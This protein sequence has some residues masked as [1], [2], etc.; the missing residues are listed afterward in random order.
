MS[1]QYCQNGDEYCTFEIMCWG[2]GFQLKFI[3]FNNNSRWKRDLSVNKYITLICREK[4][5]YSMVGHNWNPAQSAEPST[6][7][8]IN[9]KCHTRKNKH[10]NILILINLTRCISSTRFR[11]RLNEYKNYHSIGISIWDNKYT[12]IY[13]FQNTDDDICGGGGEGEL[14]WRA[15][16]PPHDQPKTCYAPRVRA[17]APNAQPHAATTARTKTD[18]PICETHNGIQ[19]VVRHPTWKT[20]FRQN[21]WDSLYYIVW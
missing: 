14:V 5:K 1:V 12:M 6:G 4:L 18:S 10:L 15:M 21:F 20:H 17:R 8:I 3:I 19:Q 7:Q 9:K 11:H 13:G 2:R 16:T